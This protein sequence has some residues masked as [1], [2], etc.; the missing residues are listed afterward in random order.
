MALI[1]KINK[2]EIPH[3][4]KTSFTYAGETQDLLG[5][6]FPLKKGNPKTLTEYIN[7][8]VHQKRRK[9]PISIVIPDQY[10]KE[11]IQIP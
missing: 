1:V 10:L 2:G 5:R 8:R 11:L 7:F 6:M 9:L 4:W 3:T